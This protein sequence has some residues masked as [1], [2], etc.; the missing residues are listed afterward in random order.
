M[1]TRLV[2]LLAAANASDLDE[3]VKGARLKAVLEDGA[4]ALARQPPHARVRFSDGGCDGELDVLLVQN[5][6]GTR[7]LGRSSPDEALQEGLRLLA[8]K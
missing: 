6:A 2:V 8:D 4:R 5:R 7:I 1:H 3:L